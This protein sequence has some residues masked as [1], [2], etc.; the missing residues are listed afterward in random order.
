MPR[1]KA[2]LV[3]VAEAKTA[4]LPLVKKASSLGL[5]NDPG[6]PDVLMGE[7]GP[8]LDKWVNLLIEFRDYEIRPATRRR[9]K[10]THNMSATEV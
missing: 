7:T 3:K 10:R 2:Y 1:K 4:A 5:A 9:P 8:A 6:A